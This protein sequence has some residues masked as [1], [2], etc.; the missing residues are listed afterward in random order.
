M[1]SEDYEFYKG[2]EFLVD[3][4]VMTKTADLNQEYCLIFKSCR[5]LILVMTSHSPPRS[6]SL[7]S[8]RSEILSMMEEMSL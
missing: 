6:R 3:N 1:E 8:R 7:V 5:L 4:Q 2:L